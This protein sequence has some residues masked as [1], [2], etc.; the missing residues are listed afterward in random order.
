MQYGA[1]SLHFWGF[2]QEE[3]VI[4]SFKILLDVVGQELKHLYFHLHHVFYLAKYFGLLDGI[5][6]LIL[7]FFL[8]AP[9]RGQ[10]LRI[11]CELG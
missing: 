10:Q 9:N 1:V 4:R 2:K 8:S 3:D 6:H 11:A 7:E 5:D